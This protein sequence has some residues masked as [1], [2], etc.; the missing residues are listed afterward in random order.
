M[1]R[2]APKL[3]SFLYASMSR[4]YITPRPLKNKSA[5]RV[6][7]A[8]ER[9]HGSG[10][11]VSLC[12]IRVKVVIEVVGIVSTGLC[13]H[14]PLGLDE[15]TEDQVVQNCREYLTNVRCLEDFCQH[16]ACPRNHEITGEH[17]VA[18]PEHLVSCQFRSPL[19]R[20]IDNVILQQRGIM[21]YLYASREGFHLIKVFCIFEWHP[22]GLSSE[23]RI[24]YGPRK[25]EKYSWSE[26]LAF[27]I[28]VVVGW[29]TQLPVLC[30]Q[31]EILAFRFTMLF[32]A[33]S[34]VFCRSSSTILNGSSILRVWAAGWPV[35]HVPRK[36]PISSSSLVFAFSS[37]ALVGITSWV[38]WI[39]LCE[40]W[41]LSNSKSSSGY[42]DCISKFVA[43]L[44]ESGIYL[45]LY[46]IR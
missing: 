19:V 23:G 5:L 11:I 4:S 40:N 13:L 8:P 35:P 2:W 31:L 15:L 30:F 22:T 36:F 26:I 24:I 33:N 10:F 6:L 14:V 29:V 18:R 12:D 28:Q 17:R 3:N 38:N 42:I 16:S 1:P 20:S 43:Y 32:K 7:P 37:S 25:H 39:A 9:D 44:G 45:L 34:L 21:R 41:L 27:Q 46:F